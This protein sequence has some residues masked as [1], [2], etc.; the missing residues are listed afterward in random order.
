MNIEKTKENIEKVLIKTHNYCD[1]K[2]I[3]E[4]NPFDCILDK[5]CKRDCV[6]RTLRYISVSLRSFKW[7]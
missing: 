1:R 5:E 6:M 3:R 7:R 2:P 4:C